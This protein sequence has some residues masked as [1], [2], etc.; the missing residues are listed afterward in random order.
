[1]WLIKLPAD[2][3][4]PVMHVACICPA[5]PG[6]LNPAIA[7]GR[8]LVRRGHRVTLISLLDAEPAVVAGGL[9]FH[10]LGQAE[11]PAGCL[12]EQTAI[13]GRLSGRQALKFTLD[14]LALSARVVYRELPQVALRSGVDGLIVD[15]IQAAGGTVAEHLKLPFVTIC[16]ALATHYE[17]AVPP[18]ATSWPY[19]DRWWARLR[20]RAGWT[21]IDKLLQPVARLD[22]QQRQ[23]WGLIPY[24]SADESYSKLAQI[25][26]QPPGFD[27][28]RQHLPPHFHYVGPL[29]DAAARPDVDFPYDRLTGQPLIYASLGTLQNQMHGVFRAMIQACEGLPAQLVLSLG[30]TGSEVRKQLPAGALV[31]DYAPQMQLLERAALCITHGGLNTTLEALRCGVPLVAIPIANDQPGVATR[32]AHVGVGE[33]VPLR[34]LTAARL[35][36]A[37]HRVLQQASYRQHAQ[38]FQRAIAAHPGPPRAADIVEQALA[39]RAAV[40]S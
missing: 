6:H 10:P 38:A 23:D 36:R 40:T 2:V 14:Q 31:V 34:Q 30:R 33:M 20:N 11:F 27:F 3:N 35:R 1:V 7:L 26:Q 21:V 9:D 32:I 16:S 29:S 22:H 18:F 4:Q 19:Q 28:P 24:R 37:V 39:S 15:Q 8:E 17:P 5:V 25:S 13:L 12:A